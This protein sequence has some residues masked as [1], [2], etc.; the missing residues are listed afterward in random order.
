MIRNVLSIAGSDP[1]GGAGIQ[2]DLK[3]FSA[4]GVYGMAVLTALTAQNTQ[5]VSGVHLVPP[6]FVADQI[7]AVFADVRV[8]AVK[9]GMIANAGIAD[10]VAG[11]LSDHRDIPIVIDPVMIAKGGAALL[12][13]EAVDVL[14]RRLLPLATLLTPNLPEAAA[15]LQ[16]PV[17]TNRADMAAQAER[18]RALGPVAVLVKGGHLDSDE[19]PDVLATAAGLH[20]FEARRVPTKNTHGT[21]CTLSSALAAELAKGASAQEAVAIA[22]DYLAGAVAAAGSLTVGSGHGPVQHF[23]ALWK[24][25]I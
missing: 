10:A 8:D 4:R 12:A 20:W 5:G 18:L 16:Q 3:A 13:P 6:Q 24:H 23:H 2:A 11:A 1:S 15:L 22:K 14:T 7:N 17:A 9:I 21:G 25:G 19:S